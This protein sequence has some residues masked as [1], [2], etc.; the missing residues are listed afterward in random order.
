MLCRYVSYLG[1]AFMQIEALPLGYS[2]ADIVRSRGG[3][4]V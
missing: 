3:G 4:V 2:V 1:L